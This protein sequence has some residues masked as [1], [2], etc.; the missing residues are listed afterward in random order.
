MDKPLDH[1]QRSRGDSSERRAFGS[2]RDVQWQLFDFCHFGLR[3][4]QGTS[5]KL[6]ASARLGICA[7]SFWG[8]LWISAV[9]C[10]CKPR[11]FA[12]SFSLANKPHSL[13]LSL[14]R[15]LDLGLYCLSFLLTSLS[16]SF[17]RNRV[18]RTA[19]WTTSGK[20]R[21]ATTNASALVFAF[22]FS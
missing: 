16:H 7:T 10:G 4:K 18:N 11:D 17:Q 8:C 13:A 15:C 14:F 12:F 20:R 19:P 6:I 1:V 3:E 21:R 22:I 2:G 5:V 9:A